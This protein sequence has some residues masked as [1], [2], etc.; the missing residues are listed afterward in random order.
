[1]IAKAKTVWMNFLA[2]SV[3][4]FEIYSSSVFFFLFSALPN[5][6]AAFLAPVFFGAAFF[7]GAS[8]TSAAASAVSVFAVPRLALGAAAAPPR[9]AFLLTVGVMADSFLPFSPG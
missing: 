2:H 3:T 5:L 8:L 7:S 4:P 1:V 6:D 9:L